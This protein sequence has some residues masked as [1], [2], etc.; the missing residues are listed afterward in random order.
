[1]K[2]DEPLLPPVILREEADELRSHLDSINQRLHHLRSSSINFS[3]LLPTFVHTSLP[4]SFKD[5]DPTKAITA[6][7]QDLEGR[8]E[9]EITIA[10][11]PSPNLTNHLQTWLAELIPK[12]AEL[13][14]A[15]NPSIVGGVV[16]SVGGRIYDFSLV[17]ALQRYEQV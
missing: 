13:T 8:Q 16:I 9:V 7:R 2:K 11:R 4:P 1:M 3:E 15:T 12:P 10:I 14:I 6:L 17:K 5:L